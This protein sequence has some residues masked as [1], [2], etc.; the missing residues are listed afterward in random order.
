MIRRDPWSVIG[1]RLPR[2]LIGLLLCGTGIASMVVADLGLGPWDVFHQGVAKLTGVPIGTVGI[3]AGFVVLLGWLPL[4]ERIG[5]GTICNVILIGVVIDVLLMVVT[6]PSSLVLRIVLMGIGPLLFGVGSGL[7]IGAGL[8]PGPRDGLMTGIAAR[9]RPV[10]AVRLVME[11]TVLALGAVLGGRVG[12]GTVLFAVGIG[13]IV[14]LA[15]RHLS[16]A[17]IDPADV[18]VTSVGAE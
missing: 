3:L 7:Y 18:G 8:G 9:G 16:V 1:P 4:R 6:P 5:V 14:H 2:L 13:P 10:W 12:L 15:L 17:P 11:L